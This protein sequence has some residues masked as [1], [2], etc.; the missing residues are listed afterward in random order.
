ML[1]PV[2][3]ARPLYT[4]TRGGTKPLICTETR[5]KAFEAIKTVLISAPALEFQ[6]KGVLTQTSGPQK[7]PLTIGPCNYSMAH[8]SKSWGGGA[9]ASLMKK[10]NMLKLG[11]DL[12]LTASHDRVEA[13]L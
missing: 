7:Y 3:T 13:L 8:L 9:T 2:E 11:Q 1:L 5:Q 4:S 12:K 6:T 10:A